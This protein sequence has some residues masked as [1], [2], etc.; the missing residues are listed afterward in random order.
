MMVCKNV[1]F[2]V[3]FQV[4]LIYKIQV[5]YVVLTIVLKGI[6]NWVYLS[7]EVR[8]KFPDIIIPCKLSILL[9][10]K[11]QNIPQYS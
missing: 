8:R 5:C 9:N 10:P 7:L 4:C 6:L 11:T 3:I 2:I 1:G